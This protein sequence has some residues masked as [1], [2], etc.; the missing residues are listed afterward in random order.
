MS[1][2]VLS[3][4]QG[5]NAILQMRRIITGDLDA[6][7]RNLDAQGRILSDPGVWDG[8]LARQFRGDVWPQ[9][10]AA[11]DKVLQELEVL[12]GKVELINQEITRAGGGR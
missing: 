7:I 6:Q 10:K 9:T 11:L 2:K 12:R 3:T 8:Q 5:E 4:V 1:D